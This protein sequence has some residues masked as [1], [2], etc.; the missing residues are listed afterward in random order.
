MDETK[1]NS[2][3]IILVILVHFASRII[4]KLKCVLGTQPNQSLLFEY[5]IILVKTN[6][7]VFFNNSQ[8]KLNE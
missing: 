8:A 4:I 3:N 2:L 6:L 5:V 7:T 1:F